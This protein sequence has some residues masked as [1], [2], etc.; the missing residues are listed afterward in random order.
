ME[1]LNPATFSIQAGALEPY[2]MSKVS[3]GRRLGVT[4]PLVTFPGL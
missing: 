4:T 1:C 2:V 3:K